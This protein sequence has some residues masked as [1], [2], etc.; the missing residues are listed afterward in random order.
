[1]KLDSDAWSVLETIRLADRPPYDQ[2]SVEDARAAYD[3]GRQATMAEPQ[4]VGHVGDLVIPSAWGGIP[5]RLYR[6][7][8]DDKSIL[9]LFVFFHGGGWVLGSLDSHDG[10]CRRLANSSQCAVLAIGYRLAPEHP[11]PAAFEDAE[12]AVR[13]ALQEAASLGADPKRIAVGGDSAG[14]NLAAAVCHRLRDEGGRM[15]VF[16]L[17]IYPAVD[18]AMDTKS[19]RLFA[20]GHL[21]TSRIQQWFHAHYLGSTA[22]KADWRVSPLRAER[23]AGLPP[24][25]ILTASHDPLRDEGEAYGRRLYEAGVTTTIIRVPG[26]IHGFLPMDKVMRSAPAVAACLG[27]HLADAVRR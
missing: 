8:T 7:V 19:H 10:L 5:A 13:W 25:F 27:R 15:P 26:Q 23:F 3:A 9:P 20:E 2:M 24:A 14:G 17:L 11:F 12:Q 6:P 18:F 16:Q 21:L 4:A 22:S 1:M